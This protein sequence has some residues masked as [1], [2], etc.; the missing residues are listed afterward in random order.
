VDLK[1]A[2]DGTDLSQEHSAC[3]LRLIYVPRSRV[4]NVNVWMDRNNPPDIPP[5]QHHLRG[6]RSALRLTRRW[7][8]LRAREGWGRGV[9][10]MNQDL[11]AID[12]RRASGLR[13][14]LSGSSSARG[15]ISSPSSRLW[16]R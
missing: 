11:R 12:E 4:S 1:K 13:E 15:T 10:R 3:A 7:V 9:E 16:P 2:L 14:F 8:G 5:V 6:L